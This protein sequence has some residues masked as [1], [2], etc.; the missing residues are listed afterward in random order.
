MLILV[1]VDRTLLEIRQW[2][3]PPD[4][5]P[6]YQKALK[7]RHN[8]TGGWLVESERFVKWKTDSSSVLWLFGIPGCGK[9]ILSSTV[10]E[11]ITQECY[12]DSS[13]AVAFYYFKFN[14]S[15]KQVPELMIK[16]LICQLLQRCSKMPGAVESMFCAHERGRRQPT[17]DALLE[18]LRELIQG[19][20]IS[21]VVL[22]ALDEC[23]D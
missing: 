19:L 1:F 22:D 21:Y 14:D 3:S 20:P 12:A 6:D 7:Q 18:A 5:F 10:I 23:N 2:L 9:T 17:L 15:L 16:S 8:H 13:K 4:P 11:N